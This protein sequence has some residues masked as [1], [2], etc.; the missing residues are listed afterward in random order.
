MGLEG[1]NRE[2]KRS[3]RKAINTF[4]KR[5][6]KGQ[7]AQDKEEYR[8]QSNTEKVQ[9]EVLSRSDETHHLQL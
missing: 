9:G 8:N 7:T 1:W 6:L 5:D 2:G 4:L 3:L